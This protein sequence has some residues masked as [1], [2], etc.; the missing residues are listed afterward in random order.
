LR[1]NIPKVNK[2][3]VSAVIDLITKIQVILE[4]NDS[5]VK[6][7]LI[8]TPYWDQ[9]KEL[10]RTINKKSF[11]KLTLKFKTFDGAQGKEAN[12]VIL[13][14]VRTDR[15]RGH[16]TPGFLGFLWNCKSRLSV[17]MSRT[18]DYLF[19]VCRINTFI[20]DENYRKVIF[21]CLGMSKVKELCKEEWNRKWENIY[22]KPQVF[23]KI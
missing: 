16:F 18:K 9:L 4:K 17:P 14:M 23:D 2:Q 20:G 21:N 22:N 5:P 15:F 13:S 8:T 1:N 6:E 7:V 12:I 3:E 11:S 10:K 19:M